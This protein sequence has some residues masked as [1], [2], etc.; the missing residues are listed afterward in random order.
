NAH[1]AQTID[2]L[3][4]MLGRPVEPTE[5]EAYTWRFVE[6]GRKVSAA[7]YIGAM[8]LLHAWARRMASWWAEGHDLLVTPTLA[9]PPPR[10]GELGGPGGDPLQRWQR[11]L[12]VIPYTP[13]MNVTGQ[14][15]IS[16]PLHWSAQGLPVGV[17]LIGA[18]GREDLLFRVAAQLEQASPWATRKPPISA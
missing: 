11:N 13:A 16:L 15:A 17:H 2:F 9:A 7:E 12:E 14:P 5:V 18:Y 10:L 8:D 3:G 4:Q 6:D 1:T